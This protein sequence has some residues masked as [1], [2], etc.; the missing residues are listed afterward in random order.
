MKFGA[1]QIVRAK[2]EFEGLYYREIYTVDEPRAVNPYGSL[3]C[4]TLFE[5]GKAKLIPER[6]LAEYW[7]NARAAIAAMREPTAEMIEAGRD[8]SISESFARGIWDLMIG[9]ALA[10]KD[11]G[12]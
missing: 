6:L 9:A 11:T 10:E 8:G 1:G 7:S 2:Y 5:T 4:V 3:P 12:E